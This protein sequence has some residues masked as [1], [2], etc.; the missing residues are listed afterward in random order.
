MKPIL[1]PPWERDF[2]TNGM[3][4]L[5]ECTDCHVTEERN[6]IYEVEFSYPVTGRHFSEIQEGY[7]IG[8]IHDDKKDIQ[9]FEIYRRSAP[10][11]GIVT[12]YAHHISYRLGNV[13][14]KPLTAGSPAQ[15]MARIQTDT[16]N[17]NP[18]TFWTDKTGTATFTVSV[19]AS[20][21]E[22]LGGSEGSILDTYGKGEYEWDKWAVKL[23]LNRGRNTG[24]KIRYGINMTDIKHDKDTSAAYSAV[25]PY[26]MNA[27]T[28]E[29][30]TLPEGFVVSDTAAQ[31]AP[32]T[33]E[34][35]AVLTTEAGEHLE[36]DYFYIRPV[37]LDL[38]ERFETAPT[39][40]QLRA[41][42][43]SHLAN[44][45]NT[46]PDE[47]IEVDF[48]ALWQTP[49]YADVAPLQRVSL[50]DT[51]SVYHSVLGVEAVEKKVIKTVYDVLRERY[52]KME[53]GTAKTSFAEVIRAQAEDTILRDVPT[54]SAMQ[55]A[56]NA[57]TKL[58]TGG[59]GGHVVIAVNANGQPNEILIMDTE[60]INTAVNVLRI[61]AAGI[62]FSTT[63]YNGPFRSA[64]TIDGHFV[65]DFI[66]TGTL[67]ANLLKAGIITDRQGRNYWNLETG[68]ISISLA[69]GEIG[70][71]TSADLERVENNA[72]GYANAAEENAKQYTD[73]SLSDYAT[74]EVVDGKISASLAGLISQFSAEY[75]KQEDTIT[76]VQ[77]WYYQST[78]PTQ[79]FGGAWSLTAPAWVDGLYMWT[80]ERTI[81]A[82][83]TYTDSAPICISGNTG[84]T[85]AAG[86]PGAQGPAGTDG[87]D[88][89]PGRDGADGQDALYLY[90]T[91]DASTATAKES[92]ASVTLTA[93]VGR[94]DE[95][96]IDPYGYN[97]YYAWFINIDGA[98]ETYYSRGKTRTITID[99]SL[100]EDKASIRFAL[101]GLEFFSLT[102]E[103]DNVI[104]DHLGNYLEVI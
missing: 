52:D 46:E 24:V 16:Y 38:S 40:A 103:R 25:A 31:F 54:N 10:I 27:E 12:F 43:L 19:P 72:R 5:A 91:A 34:T 86:T 98:G 35:R 44:T 45:E 64:W 76:A 74:G 66:N 61:N 15:A 17:D 57:A 78:S 83:G 71:V 85:G 11:D 88:G 39:E 90:I 55:N 59:L 79:L 28:G 2:I 26:W 14:L 13:I 36:A 3:G 75:A 73:D 21:K 30:V 80:F 77:T 8:A 7:F 94:G 63:G 49:Q 9:P 65:A 95:A 47:N 33:T 18:F 70:A 23:Y 60:D 6:G 69:P 89:A 67:D 4:R 100:C 53:L 42:A 41:A 48:I 87:R 102:D 32:L 93:C 92:P 1:Y 20:V 82:D 84:A 81:K 37:P 101:V 62:G 56:I 97:Y 104:T 99:Q 96:D 58:I 22:K 68:E 29:T 50:C 51:V